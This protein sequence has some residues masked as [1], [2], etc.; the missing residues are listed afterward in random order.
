MKFVLP[1]KLD[2]QS[3]GEWL[4]PPAKQWLARL[5]KQQPQ[6]WR[7]FK[8]PGGEEV[9]ITWGQF[10]DRIRITVSASGGY[11]VNPYIRRISTNAFVTLPPATST[12]RMKLKG[13][14]WKAF[15][16]Y[17]VISPLTQI[18]NAAK[19]I[20]TGGVNV[21]LN[22]GSFSK[23][24][25]SLMG[26]SPTL[27][28][29]AFKHSYETL[30]VPPTSAS[31]TLAVSNFNTV[32]RDSDT[33]V[34]LTIGGTDWRP[35]STGGSYVVTANGK[36][37][38]MDIGIVGAPFHQQFKLNIDFSGTPQIIS[39]PIPYGTP[40]GQISDVLTTSNFNTSEHIH[41]SVVHDVHE[42]ATYPATRGLDSAGNVVT[43]TIQRTRI[44]SQNES[45]NFDDTSVFHTPSQVGDFSQDSGT[46]SLTNTT[47][48]SVK[49]TLPSGASKI[50]PYVNQNSSESGTISSFRL[51]GALHTT[52]SGSGGISANS[53]TGDISLLY[54]DPSIPIAVYE[55]NYSTTVLET[56]GSAFLSFSPGTHLV[57]NFKTTTTTYREVGVLHGSTDT[58]LFTDVSS[59]VVSAVAPH[60]LNGGAIFVPAS[61][62]STLPIN[63]NPY[64][65]RVRTPVFS[66]EPTNR[67]IVDVKD[68]DNWLVGVTKLKNMDGQP[69]SSFQIYTG[70]LSNAAVRKSFIDYIIKSL[71]THP[72]PV[73]AQALADF[74]AG[75]TNLYE[76]RLS[77]T[78]LGTLV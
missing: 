54:S 22:P 32:I 60:T 61:A 41:Q 28:L 26:F 34:P 9:Q 6:G 70:N 20:I 1:P 31:K 73:D 74:T 77:S 10:R 27:P 63:F 8:L 48:G 3:G 45:Y 13:G 33:G 64:Q 46:H 78:D 38:L 7:S 37:L 66:F 76:I 42:D 25:F 68:K 52:F 62:S 17:F 69:L 51:S 67:Y 11:V 50:V 49:L 58:V 43:T 59:P 2:V 21:T 56:V 65:T 30:D 23:E 5:A 18:D 15:P 36:T 71:D 12:T 53:Q 35:L 47:T 57:V 39:T 14:E 72:T 4:I 29:H 44:L 75:A 24:T 55:H 40:Y 16:G 19:N